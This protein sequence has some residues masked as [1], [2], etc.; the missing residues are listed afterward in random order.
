[1]NNILDL[2]NQIEGDV[3]DDEKTLNTYS[4]D[5]SIFKVIP[6]TVIYPKI[7]TDLKKIIKF[8]NENNNISITPRSAGTDMSGGPLNNSI[9]LDFTKY[10]N[11]IIEINEKE[12]YAIVEPGV[13]FRD[14][15]KEISKY[16]MFYPAYPASKDLCAIGGMISNNSGGERTL[17]YG[18]TEKHVISLKAILQDGNEYEFCL[19]NQEDLNQKLNQKNFEGYVYKKIYNLIEKNYNLVQQN[20]PQVSKNSTGYNIWN[21]LNK[22]NKTFNLGQI[23]I[24]AQGTLGL[25]TQAKLNLIK[26]ANYKKLVAV[27][28]KNIET[29]PHI[30]NEI[31]KFNPESIESF[32]DKTLS[33][34]IK[35]LPQIIKMMKGNALKLFLKFMPEIYLTITN[36]IPKMILLINFTDDDEKELESNIEN[37]RKILNKYNVKY[38]I[39]KDEKE[40]EKYWTIR[41]YS[42]KLLHGAI[43]NRTAAPFIDD[44]VIKPQYLPEILPKINKILENHKDKLIYT[45]AG[46]PGEG[47]FHII[48]LLDLRNQES[49][50]LILKIMDEVYDLIIKYGGSISG[51]HNDGMIRTPYLEKMYKPEIIKIFEEIKK[52]FDPKNIFNPGKKV[53]Y[54]KNFILNHIKKENA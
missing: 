9:I 27:F 53:F 2:K 48:P 46:H 13:Y 26:E 14:L 33:T 41:R 18:K 21:I 17:K 29:A 23:F 37:F 44:F 1:M 8:A 32:D 15:E 31:L 24:G 34:A 49:R 5:Y 22:E 19:L 16:G 10:F 50:D 51:E 45:I 35:F 39:I 36:G 4:T 43:K 7:I 28:L 12:K 54:D 30:V 6:K 25:V 47:N 40:A 20:K 52:I 11:K 38:K 3:L 42:F